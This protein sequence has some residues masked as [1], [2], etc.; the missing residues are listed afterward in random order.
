M[1]LGKRPLSQTD[2]TDS[3]ITYETLEYLTL[4]SPPRLGH[5]R[6]VGG[7]SVYRA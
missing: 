3:V 2:A 4:E 6:G 5:L 7:T 1:D